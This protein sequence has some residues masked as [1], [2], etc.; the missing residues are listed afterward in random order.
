MLGRRLLPILAIL[1]LGL[2]FMAPTQAQEAR[3]V[4]VRDLSQ[5]LQAVVTVQGRTGY[6]AEKYERQS[7]HVF[8]LRDDYN[9]QV[10]VRTMAKDYPVM[11]VTYRVTGWATQ[12][13]G[14]LFLDTLPGHILPAYPSAP[15]K[16]SLAT[17]AVVLVWIAGIL[18]GLA[19]LAGVGLAL[20]VLL[21]R[22]LPEWG[23]LTVASGPDK[24]K[25]VSLRRRR[26]PLG[27]GVSA[28]RGIRLSAGDST[29]SN[30][31]AT[32][33]YR[34]GA[35]FCCDTSRNGTRIGGERLKMGEPTRINSG[36][37][38]HLGTQGTVIIIRMR[39]VAPAVGL[40]SHLREPSPLSD[41]TLMFPDQA[42][43][44]PA[45]KRHGDGPAPD[46]EQ[47]TKHI[48]DLDAE[49]HTDFDAAEPSER[50]I[51]SFVSVPADERH[52]PRSGG[53]SPPPKPWEE[54]E[55]A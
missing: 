1:G 50:P 46:E 8:T 27:R 34:N 43:D 29:I 14:V 2:T 47:G 20:R 12:E 24:G 4:R 51:F 35:L 32:F 26:V 55:V 6:I 10:F 33:I 22:T 15:S 9:D 39:E 53:S 36:D 52:T 13:N 31:H 40:L 30:L 37:L 48:S 28:A 45:W 23:E 18:L 21:G 11:G 3:Q 41:Q 44:E 49:D 42:P 16:P 7:L 54:E 17:G 25:T 38:I 5:H 19:V